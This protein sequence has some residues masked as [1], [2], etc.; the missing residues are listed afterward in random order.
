MRLRPYRLRHVVIVVFTA[1]GIGL[2]PW[3]IYLSTSLQSHHVTHRWDL[4]W[5]GYDV[6]LSL[7]FLAT[8]FAAYRRS[9]WVGALSASLGTMLIVDAWFDIVLESHADELRQ[10]VTLALVAELPAAAFCVWIAV[11]TERFL[12]LIMEAVEE[13]A[14]DLH[15]PAAGERPAEGDFVG[16]LEVPPDGKAAG[17]P[18][19]A[20]AAA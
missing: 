14:D 11:R 6:A 5:T 1:A 7:V 18:R 13:A 8:A 10:S 15:L 17:E 20:D 3:T 19:D 9:P 16:V 12:A 4:A 2:L